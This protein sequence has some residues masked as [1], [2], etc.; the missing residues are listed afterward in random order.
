MSTLPGR[1]HT[2]RSTP[3]LDG[4]E[5]TNSAAKVG[6]STDRAGPGYGAPYPENPN[7]GFYGLIYSSSI[8]PSIYQTRCI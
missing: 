7:S 6:K 2:S 8:L 1:D 3:S 5:G 4:K